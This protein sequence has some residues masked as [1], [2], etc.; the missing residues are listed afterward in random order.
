M[1]TLASDQENRACVLGGETSELHVVL[2]WHYGSPASWLWHWEIIERVGERAGT[3]TQDPLIKS[4]MLVWL[5]IGSPALQAEAFVA[6]LLH[7]RDHQVLIA[8]NS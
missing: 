5:E 7:Q 3:R 4:Q 8:A 2:W 1:H 6:F